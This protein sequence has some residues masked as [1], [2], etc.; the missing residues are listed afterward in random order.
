MGE[1]V[2]I[3]EYGIALY[4][5]RKTDQFS[6]WIGSIQD[7]SLLKR[8][9]P[10]YNIRQSITSGGS[11]IEYSPVDKNERRAMACF[12]TSIS[13]LVGSLALL[14]FTIFS[15]HDLIFWGLLLLGS[16]MGFLMIANLFVDA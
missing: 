1:E 2:W 9:Y 12:A 4:P 16:S 10:R 7:Q 11:L 13:C 3:E 8:M 14:V 5:E 6:F 15:H